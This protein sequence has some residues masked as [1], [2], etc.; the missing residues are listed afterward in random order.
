MTSPLP[1][2]KRRADFVRAARAGRKWVAPGLIVQMLRRSEADA[3]RVPEDAVRVGFTTS[4]KVGKA[5]AR[6]RARRRLREVARQVL[7]QHA[8]AGCDYVII[9]RAET[10]TRPFT[11]LLDDLATAVRRLQPDAAGSSPPARGRRRGR[12]PS[13]NETAAP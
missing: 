9:G 3:E 12:R 8:V 4:R 2:L 11:A 1:R 13:K 6:N 5:V 10:L 7:P